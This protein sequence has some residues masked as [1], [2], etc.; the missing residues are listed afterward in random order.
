MIFIP[1]VLHINDP[2]GRNATQSGIEVSIDPRFTY[3]R[4]NATQRGIEV[5][6]DPKYETFLQSIA[7]LRY[8]LM[9]S[10]VGIE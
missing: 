7:I 4:R 2:T 1:V 6:I 8:Y 3:K 9:I 5:S 10:E